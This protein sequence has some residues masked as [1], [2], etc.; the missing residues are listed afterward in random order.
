RLSELESFMDE[1]RK[2]G[3]S[4]GARI[5]II[6]SNVP[7]GLGEPVFDKLEAAMAHGMMS[8]NAV[9]GV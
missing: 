8:I 9:K 4:I 5:N 6:A 1:L 7:A 3:D 2:S